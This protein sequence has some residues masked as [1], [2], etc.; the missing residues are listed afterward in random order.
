MQGSEGTANGALTRRERAVAK[1]VAT[2]LSN[3][4]VAGSLGVTV[5]AVEKHLGSIY[6]K[7]ALPSRGKLIVYLSGRTVPD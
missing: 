4:E 3:A 1:L 7:L 2:G 6:K 5:K